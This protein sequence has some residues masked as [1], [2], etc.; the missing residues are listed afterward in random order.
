MFEDKYDLAKKDILE[1]IYR[2][3]YREVLE[4]MI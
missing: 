3:D 2:H 4:T 1:N